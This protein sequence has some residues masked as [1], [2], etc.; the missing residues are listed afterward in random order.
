M[1]KSRLTDQQMEHLVQRSLFDDAAQVSARSGTFFAIQDRLGEQSG[2]GLRQQISDAFENLSEAIWKIIP[3]SKLRMAQALALVL[4][5]VVVGTYIAFAGSED[6]TESDV[7]VEPVITPEATP[8]AKLSVPQN[9]VP[10]VDLNVMPVRDTLHA[11]AMVLP[12][13][14]GQSPGFLSFGTSIEVENLNRELQLR[15]M[16]QD[17]RVLLLVFAPGVD[18]FADGD[19]LNL[20][21]QI[22]QSFEPTQAT[23]SLTTE[24]E[25]IVAIEEVAT[26]GDGRGVYLQHST[27]PVE[28]GETFAWDVYVSEADPSGDFHFVSIAEPDSAITHDGPDPKRLDAKFSAVERVITADV[29]VIIVGIFARDPAIE[30]MCKK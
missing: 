1:D 14:V 2:R 5:V 29:G 18:L 26:C 12:L 22:N 30:E 23:S 9:L 6:V 28:I 20:T 13:G 27:K 21:Q 8:I 10:F 7:A 16:F 19:V 11:N 4:I 15:T 17:N 25:R 24:D 3:V